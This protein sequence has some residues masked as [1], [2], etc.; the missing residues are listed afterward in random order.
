MV[1]FRQPASDSVLGAV[2]MKN[3]L[4][5][6]AIL[7][8]IL[9]SNLFVRADSIDKF[10]IEQMKA[11]QLPGLSV[12]VIRDGKVIRATGYGFANLELRVPAVQRHR[13][14]NRLDLKAIRG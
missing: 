10:I 1:K 7:S 5:T 11:R 13:L 8:L 14:R 6:I 2:K 3:T 9:C 4:K 12:A